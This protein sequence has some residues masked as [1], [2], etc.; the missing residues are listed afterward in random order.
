M[1][2][3][4]LLACLVAACCGLPPRVDD[5]STPVSAFET[6]RGA[7][8]RAEYDREW[9]C[10][11]DP[12]RERLGLQNSLDWK[13]ARAFVLHQ[14][15]LAVKGIRC[16][17]VEGAPVTL[18]DGRVRIELS[19]PLGYEARVWMRPILVLRAQAEAELHAT[20]R[21]FTRIEVAEL[22]F[23]DGFETGEEDPDSVRKELEE[24]E[25]MT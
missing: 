2:K 16:S 9:A 25:L 24:R 17:E 13:D 8:A 21:R 1:R 6:F 12:L 5:R 23:L 10:L 4:L 11:S 14:G 20:G 3:G 18:E 15:H 22:W 19:L 7:V